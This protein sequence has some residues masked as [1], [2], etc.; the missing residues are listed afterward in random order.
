VP[1]SE[2][3]GE[4]DEA[5]ELRKFAKEYKKK[6]RDSEMFVETDASGTVPIDLVANVE[7][8]VEQQ[9]IEHE[10]DLGSEDFSYDDATDEEGH[11]VRRKSKFVRYNPMLEVLQFSLG[12]V[13]RSKNEMR[14]ALTKYGLVT[15]RSIL[16][17]KSE[18]DRVRA[19]CG[20]PG[21]PWLI[22]GAKTSRCSRFQVITYES[23]H[24]CAP[25]RDNK[26]VT[27]KVI[28]KRYEQ[29]MLANPTW[30]IDSIKSTILKD[31]F[32]DV[33]T[34]KCKAAKK[35]VMAKLLGGLKEEYTKV[36]DYQLE[37]LRSN[38][39]STVAVC[40]DP[41]IIERNIF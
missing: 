30:K 36:F 3:S 29:F 8:V 32:A 41:S 33:S 22:Y 16:F 35:I 34:S 14:K 1:H 11:I 18:G 5:V 28:A 37:L 10:F 38:P 23:E 12:M 7:E 17:M 39:G 20:S 4:D 25:N 31:F 21:C 13:F 26:L 6:L 15:H 9:N 40:L 2:D 19:K 27:A 24:H